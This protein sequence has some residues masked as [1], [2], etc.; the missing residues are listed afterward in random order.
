MATS[1]VSVIRDLQGVWTMEKTLSTELDPIF[2]LQGIGWF[3]RR[4][5]ALATINLHV[6]G[7]T[8]IDPQTSR[9]MM[10]IDI[11]QKATGG[12]AGT[13]EKR[14]LDRE[15]R[16]HQDY[17][18]GS[19]KHR[20]QLIGGSPDKDGITRPDFELQTRLAEREIKEF[21]RAE[22]LP[23]GERS[24]GFLVEASMGEY[25]DR[26]NGE[27]VH[28]FAINGTSGWTA[29]QVWTS[30]RYQP[31]MKPPECSRSPSDMGL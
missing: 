14:T 27:W 9:L 2:K 25:S 12:L 18:F 30:S 29:E 1:F 16:N 4:A 20:S 26:K 7:S 10:N 28:T 13:T 8:K 21:L 15:W 31:Y 5:L 19:L 24:G 3:I 11:A 17:L 22:I 23:G 6:S